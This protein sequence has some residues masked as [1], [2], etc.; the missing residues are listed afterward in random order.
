MLYLS[1]GTNIGDKENN[2]H[3]AIDFI[4]EQ[5]G[6]VVSQSA[7][8][9]TEPW[10]FESENSF[11]NACVGVKTSLSPLEVLDCCQKIEKSMGRRHKSKTVRQADGSTKAIYH[12]RIIDIDILLYDD[13]Q[14]NTPRLTIP[15]PLMHKRLFVLEP[16]SE[17]AYEVNIPGTDMSVGE[18]WRA[19]DAE[20]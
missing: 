16:L 3:D 20:L 14:I 8:L 2:L 6:T 7:F 18:M 11:L 19:L 13:L 15:H 5:I 9:C 17:I 12:D 10:G 4:E 1:L